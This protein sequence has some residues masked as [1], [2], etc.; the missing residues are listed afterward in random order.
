MMIKIIEVEVA[1]AVVRKGITMTR[2]FGVEAVSG[3]TRQGKRRG[4]N[5][6]TLPIIRAGAVSAARKIVGGAS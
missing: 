3:A 4:P 2:I 1:S 6:M 5:R